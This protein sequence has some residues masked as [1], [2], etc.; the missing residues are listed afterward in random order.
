MYIYIYIYI[1]YILCIFCKFNGFHVCNLF[2]KQ[3][4]RLRGSY[5]VCKEFGWCAR[6]C[7]RRPL[8]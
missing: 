4:L 7:R 6:I 3:R 2:P 5:L 1:K 8:A